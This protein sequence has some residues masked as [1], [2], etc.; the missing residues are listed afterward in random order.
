MAVSES[1]LLERERA[2]SE[3]VRRYASGREAAAEV[4]VLG[5]A[6]TDFSELRDAL[7]EAKSQAARLRARDVRLALPNGRSVASLVTRFI[8]SVE[9]DV[10]A[11][12]DRADIHRALRQHVQAYETEVRD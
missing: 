10:S 7:L 9:A 1:E 11:V 8:A 3:I 12:A 5:Q 6:E 4:F 2:V